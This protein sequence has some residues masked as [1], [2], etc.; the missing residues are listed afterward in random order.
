L[1]LVLLQKVDEGIVFLFITIVDF[2][3]KE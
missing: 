1:G 2:D 3:K